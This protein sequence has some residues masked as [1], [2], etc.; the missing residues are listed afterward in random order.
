MRRVTLVLGALAIFCLRIGDVTAGTLRVIFLVNGRRGPA[1]ALAFC[2]SAIWILA[3]SRVF[4]HLDV[5][6]NMVGY[7]C[8]YACGTLVGISVDQFIGVGRSIVRIITRAP[9]AGLRERLAAEGYGVT[10]FHGEGVNGPVQELVVVISRRRRK[11]LLASVR[12]TDPAG[13]HHRRGRQPNLRRLPRPA[14]A[15][16]QQVT[17]ARGG[18]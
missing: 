18:P 3:I 15:G 11:A 14:G 9:G 17:R 5:W 10:T 4:A 2:E 6:Q 8:G 16:P 13:V 12:A 7:A 1:M